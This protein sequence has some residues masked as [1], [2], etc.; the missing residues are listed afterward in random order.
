M[1]LAAEEKGLLVTTWN[2]APQLLNRKEKGASFTRRKEKGAKVKNSGKDIEEL[3][4]WAIKN[5]KR[6]PKIVQQIMQ[7]DTIKRPVQKAIEP[8]PT[9]VTINLQELK[10]SFGNENATLIL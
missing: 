1:K 2:S 5:P 7:A 9:S 3:Q 10:A 4:K 6:N 8:K